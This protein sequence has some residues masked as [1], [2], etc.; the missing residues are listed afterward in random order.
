VP[1]S[2][3]SITNTPVTSPYSNLNTSHCSPLSSSSDVCNNNNNSS[4]MNNM[5]PSPLTNCTPLHAAPKKR[6]LNAMKQ[7]AQDEQQ[8]HLDDSLKQQNNHH[9]ISQDFLPVP[10]TIREQNVDQEKQQTIREKPLE[11]PTTLKVVPDVDSP[12][13]EVIKKVPSGFLIGT[14]SSSTGAS[15]STSSSSSNTHFNY[16]N[17]APSIP[18]KISDNNNSSFQW[19]SQI[20]QFRRLQ[21]LNIGSQ[22][23]NPLP[24]TPYTPPPMLSPFRKGPGL[25]CNIF[26]QTTPQITT[27]PTPV[28]PFAPVT[29]EISGP[30]INI[31]GDYQAAIPKLQMKNED[32]DTGL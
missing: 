26:S 9:H 20:S 18:S 30:K 2:A 4:I 23:P 12:I 13:P 16:E 31:G 25:Y 5:Q 1:G 28:L 8:I 21:S 3:S 29:D 19:P 11:N 7:E 14:P 10:S 22:T 27:V 17:L 6:I 24:S 15:S 32:D